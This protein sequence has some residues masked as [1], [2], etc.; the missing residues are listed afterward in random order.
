MI[1]PSRA[2][3]KNY[4]K[5]IELP[6]NPLLRHLLNKYIKNYLQLRKP[7]ILVSCAHNKNLTGVSQV[8][9]P[10]DLITGVKIKRLSQQLI[11]APHLV[12]SKASLKNS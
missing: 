12:E 3:I 8:R 7:V 9:V 2:Y 5:K 10:D 1:G 11:A 6:H 4:L